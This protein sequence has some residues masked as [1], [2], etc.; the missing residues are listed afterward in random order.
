MAGKYLSGRVAEL[1]Q[2]P[3]FHTE[4][5]EQLTNLIVKFPREAPPLFLLRLSKLLRQ[6]SQ[7]PCVLLNLSKVSGRGRLERA[8]SDNAGKRNHTPEQKRKT[9]SPL[10]EPREF[11]IGT[12]DLLLTLECLSG[13]HV[14]NALGRG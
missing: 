2:I 11:L 10:Q 7:F 4:S 13:T 6:I 1:L 8:S 12:H 5:G 14:A 3:E 9:Y